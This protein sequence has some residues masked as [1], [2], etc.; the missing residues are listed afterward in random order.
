MTKRSLA[1]GAPADSSRLGPA[2]PPSFWPIELDAAG[3]AGDPQ[4]DGDT[5]RPLEPS[6][7]RATDQPDRNDAGRPT[8]REPQLVDPA[9]QL[10]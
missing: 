3:R 7:V 5:G 2:V 4:L 10:E 6:V 1:V 8:Q 9:G